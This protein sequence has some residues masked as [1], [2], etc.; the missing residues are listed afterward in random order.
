LNAVADEQPFSHTAPLV[1]FSALPL[2]RM[3][4]SSITGQGSIGGAP[5][6]PIVPIMIADPSMGSMCEQIKLCSMT[7]FL[8]VGLE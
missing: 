1:L 6:S 7:Q 5:E 2:Y 3:M 4:L 8:M